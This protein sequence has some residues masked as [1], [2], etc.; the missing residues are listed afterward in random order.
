MFK[1]YY[2]THGVHLN[3][4]YHKVLALGVI[5]VKWYSTFFQLQ[6]WSLTIQCNFVSYSGHSL[7]GDPTTLKQVGDNYNCSL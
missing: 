1:W 3:R 2:F 6:G 5:A 7:V 4:S